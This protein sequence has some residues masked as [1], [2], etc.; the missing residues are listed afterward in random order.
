MAAA[1]AAA[2]AVGAAAAAAAAAAVF[3]T[4]VNAA[5]STWAAGR[6]VLIAWQLQVDSMQ[7]QV[8]QLRHLIQWQLQ[9]LI[10]RTM[11]FDTQHL[12]CVGS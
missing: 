12:A 1:A 11:D 8:L 6:P 3:A 7:L 10:F 9:L 5:S 4:A 2:A